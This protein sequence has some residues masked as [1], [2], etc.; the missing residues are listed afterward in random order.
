[1]VKC[2]LEYEGGLHCRLGYGPSGAVVSTDA[3]VDNHGKGES[4][5]P[6][7]LMCVATAACM[8]TI[9]GIYAQEHELDL[10]GLRMDVVKEMAANPRRIARIGIDIYVPLASDSPHV[11]ELERC[12]SSSPAMQSLSTEVKVERRWHWEGYKKK[13]Q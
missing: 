3:P 7:D 10:R 1:M 12:C 5:S 4:F 9:M 2:T 6:T 13:E 8:T 11:E